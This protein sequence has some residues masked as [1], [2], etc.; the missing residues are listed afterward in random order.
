VVAIGASPAAATYPGRNGRIAFATAFHPAGEIYAIR[1]TGTGFRQLTEREDPTGNAYSPDWSPDGSEIVFS[2]D[3]AGIWMVNGDGTGL[4]QLTPSGGYATFTPDGTQIVYACDG[5]D[6]PPTNGLFIMQ[7]DG[8]DAPGV[9]LTTTP[10]TGGGQ[11][12]SAGG[13]DV[14]PQVSPDGGTV[15]FI[16]QKEEGS[17]QALFAMDIDGTNVRKLV[18][19]RFDVFIQHDWSPDGRRLVFTGTV[20]EHANVYSVAPDGSHRE[21]LTDAREGWSA[22]AGTFSPDGRWIAVR[23]S[24]A[25]RDV[26][27]LVK[28]RPDGTRRTTITTA[29][30][31]ERFIDWGTRSSE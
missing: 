27:R 28:M 15:S 22:V 17:L 19:Y 9:R 11:V 16:R 1:S 30:F 5:A 12:D 18:P 29:P 10:F 20:D 24:Q 13:G 23:F 4:T 3:G 6:C 26:Y 25:E 14:D 8:S 31:A 2:L 7:A 21:R